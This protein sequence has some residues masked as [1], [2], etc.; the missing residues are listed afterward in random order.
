MVVMNEIFGGVIVEV[1]LFLGEL[2]F[3]FFVL[4]LGKFVYK[5]FCCFVVIFIVNSG[6]SNLGY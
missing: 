2:S 5:S 6:G 4:L 1:V 3:S